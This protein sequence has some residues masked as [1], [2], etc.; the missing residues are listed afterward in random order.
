MPHYSQ[1]QSESFH[2][3]TGMRRH[4]NFLLCDQLEEIGKMYRG[5]GRMPTYTLGGG[6]NRRASTAP[7]GH[8]PGMEP[9]DW[10]AEV[11][12]NSLAEGA[13]NLTSPTSSQHLTMAQHIP[14]RTST[15]LGRP[16]QQMGLSAHGPRQPDEYELQGSGTPASQA[17]STRLH[18]ARHDSQHATHGSGA[19]SWQPGVEGADRHSSKQAASGGSLPLITAHKPASW[20]MPWQT[21]D[22]VAGRREADA[23][24][25]R[26][27]PSGNFANQEVAK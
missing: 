18:T 17:G 16:R 21:G 15:A 22:R 7:T 14:A 10:V 23:V 11:Q 6:L 12:S 27:T 13:H 3:S 1:Q 4:L 19:T 5:T 24:R 26:R 8:R 9:R 20:L 2:S 25:K